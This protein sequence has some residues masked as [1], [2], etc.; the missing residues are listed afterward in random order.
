MLLEVTRKVNPPRALFVD[1]PLGY[2]L[3]EPDNPTLQRL[4]IKRTLNLLE[5][6]APLP[7]LADFKE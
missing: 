2:P 4:V 3:G 5:S 7:I 1:Y 6:R